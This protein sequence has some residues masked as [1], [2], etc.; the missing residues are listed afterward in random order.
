V[1]EKPDGLAKRKFSN[2]I[3]Y[4]NKP[5]LVGKKT[6]SDL[7]K[8]V[9]AIEDPKVYREYAEALLETIK[10]GGGSSSASK[11]MM[12]MA[13]K[14]RPGPAKGIARASE[15]SAPAPASHFLREF[16]QSD[17]ELIESST[18]EANVAQILEI[19]NGHV[20]KMVVA[21]SGA[22]VYDALKKGT[23][24]ADKARYIYYAILSRPPNKAEMNMLMRD[25]IDGSKESY[26]NLVAAL[27]QTHEFMFV[28]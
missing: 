21:N 18:K 14:S 3:Y 26:E 7:A 1:A 17:R 10:S 25:V 24:E 22:S 23:T 27:V 20:E 8:E 19:M 5:I 4:N 28:Q 12:M 16:G 11:D 6:M 2:N 15:L 9:M 13:A